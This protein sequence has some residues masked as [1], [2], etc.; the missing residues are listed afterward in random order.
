MSFF[1]PKSKLKDQNQMSEF[2]QDSFFY[3][4]YGCKKTTKKTRIALSEPSFQDRLQCN[5][6]GDHI[7]LRIDYFSS[8]QKYLR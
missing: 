3:A 7:L 4:T 8:P 5:I 6:P 2:S 1:L